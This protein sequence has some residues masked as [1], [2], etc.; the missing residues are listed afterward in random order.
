MIFIGTNC[1]S[2]YHYSL[3]RNQIEAKFG[4]PRYQNRI[5]GL[6]YIDESCDS[7]VCIS[8]NGNIAT[9]N[10]FNAFDNLSLSLEDKLISCSS[11]KTKG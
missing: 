7:I 5:V 9:Q 4:T 2:L 10:I 3:S 11:M 6:D 8:S 1:G